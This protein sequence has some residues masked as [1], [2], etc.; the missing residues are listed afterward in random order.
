MTYHRQRY[1]Q[2]TTLT[3]YTGIFPKGDGVHLILFPLKMLSLYISFSQNTLVWHCFNISSLF[4]E[5]YLE[6]S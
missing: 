6:P 2:R 5:V 4:S 3:S 1:K